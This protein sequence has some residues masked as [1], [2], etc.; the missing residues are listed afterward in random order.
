MPENEIE[1][2]ND[3]KRTIE[4]ARDESIIFKDLEELCVSRGYAHVIAYLSFKYNFAKTC[5]DTGSIDPHENRL[6]LPIIPTEIATLIGLM[7]KQNVDLTLPHPDIFQKNLDKTKLLIQEMYYSLNKYYFIKKE[8]DPNFKT[9]MV[10]EKIFYADQS[11]CDFQYIEFAKQKYK[12]DNDWLR[13]YKGFTIEEASD[14]C[15]AILNLLKDKVKNF[16]EENRKFEKILLID[17]F[18]Y[19]PAFTFNK[20][21][22]KKFI[23]IDSK[24][25]DRVLDVFSKPEPK[26]I[27]NKQF[28]TLDSINYIN[29]CPLI[30]I[31]DE[32]YI[33]LQFYN[34]AE[35]LYIS[36]FIWMIQKDNSYYEKEGSEN[37]KNFLEKFITEKLEK[38]F[39]K[40]IFSNVTVKNSKTP[41][42]K[43]TELDVLAIVGNYII[44]FEAKS[45]GLTSESRKGNIDKLNKDL[46]QGI[47][48]AYNQVCV[49]KKL[50]ADKENIFK[51]SKGNELNI[52]N[53]CINSKVY[54]IVMLSEYYPNLNFQVRDFLKLEDDLK[55]PFVMDIFTLDIMI[56]FFETPLYF[57]TYLKWRSEQ[58]EQFEQFNI[59]H[60][61]EL[62]SHFICHGFT[63]LQSSY[64]EGYKF[65]SY[66]LLDEILLKKINH[67]DYPE[68]LLLEIKKSKLGKFLERLE[69]YENNQQ[70]A[71]NVGLFILS[72][73]ENEL[74]EFLI[75]Y[76]SAYKSSLEKRM[77]LS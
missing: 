53:A 50:L 70:T 55:N 40:N 43:N 34:L 77:V 45:K 68:Y 2:T 21:E 72:L 27:G 49:R 8:N 35:S 61:F 13:E 64:I 39:K 66:T 10:C 12:M 6:E 56:K 59:R 20:S 75:K 26:Y 24:V 74:P 37:R 57:L 29:F 7:V 69:K 54:G 63:K 71:L 3:V 48:A 15:N 14:V 11:A 60:E 28:N 9:K 36:P 4:S 44:I 52:K 67:I 38:V 51:D 31:G 19:L 65:L 76:D 16:D 73:D 5:E 23:A 47:Q 42:K 22:L 30:P 18:T 46:G 17:K 62:L 33:L 41:K 25:I 1:I 32:Q 58:V